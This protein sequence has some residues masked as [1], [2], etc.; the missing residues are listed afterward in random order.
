MKQGGFLKVS[1]PNVYGLF[2]S[3]VPGDVQKKRAREKERKRE[4]SGKGN[5]KSWKD[6]KKIKKRR[7][8]LEIVVVKVH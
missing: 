7:E 4:E 8:K 2:G 5:K 3:I 1:R 6:N